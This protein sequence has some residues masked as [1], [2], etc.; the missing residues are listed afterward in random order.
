VVTMGP[1]PVAPQIIVISSAGLDG[2]EM[3]AAVDRRLPGV[4]DIE[5]RAGS[6]PSPSQL[7]IN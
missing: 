6:P 2:S 7:P 4:F 3:S 1:I 5:R